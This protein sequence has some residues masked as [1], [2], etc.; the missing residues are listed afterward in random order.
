MLNYCDYDKFQTNVENVEQDT[1]VETMTVII[2]FVGFLVV[3]L[4]GE[5]NDLL[6]GF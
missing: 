4:W 6:G 1:D 3:Y 2:I 5:K